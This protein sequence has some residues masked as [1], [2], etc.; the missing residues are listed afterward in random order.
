MAHA[1][2]EIGSQLARAAYFG[3]AFA[4]ACGAGL[5]VLAGLFAMLLYAG[6][7]PREAFISLNDPT[8]FTSQLAAATLAGVAWASVRF[9]QIRSR[10]TL[11]ASAVLLAI[12]LG[13]NLAFAIRTGFAFALVALIVGGTVGAASMWFSLKVVGSQLQVLGLAWRH[14]GTLL[15]AIALYALVVFV[16]SA[17]YYL[18]ARNDPHALSCPTCDAPI[19]SRGEFLYFSAMTMTTLGSGRITPVSGL[20]QMLT[21]SEAIIGALIFAAYI[22]FVVANVTHRQK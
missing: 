14:L 7:S 17:T 1:P 13:Y 5:I 2:E 19:P 16:Y 4:L 6:L 10:V 20:A 21:V 22:G 12:A 15:G 18:L 8:I 11:T 9:F 3:A